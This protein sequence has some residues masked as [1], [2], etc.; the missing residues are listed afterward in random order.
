MFMSASKTTPIA[1]R[2]P[3]GGESEHLRLFTEWAVRV[4][5]RHLVEEQRVMS[6]EQRVRDEGNARG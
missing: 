5:R 4:W 3:A 6:N 1:E 2:P